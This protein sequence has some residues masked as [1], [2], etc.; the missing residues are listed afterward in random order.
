MARAIKFD[1]KINTS[2]A[3]DPKVIAIIDRE[4]CGDSRSG[5]LNDLIL[6]MFGGGY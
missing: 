1:K 6:E 5:W 3:F 2:L 4:R